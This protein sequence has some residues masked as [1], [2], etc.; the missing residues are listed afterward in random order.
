MVHTTNNDAE[1][2]FNAVA[3]KPASLNGVNTANI[4]GDIKDES[5]D[6]NFEITWNQRSQLSCKSGSCFDPWNFHIT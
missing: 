3:R 4:G 2:A 1:W 5:S 6:N